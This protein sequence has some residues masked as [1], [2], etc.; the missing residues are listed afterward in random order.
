MNGDGDF[1]SLLPQTALTTARGDGKAVALEATTVFAF[2]YADGVIVA[3]D[4]RATA[5]N[6]V[7]SDRTEKILELD[8][9]SL[10]AIAGSPAIAVEMARTLQTAFDFY[11]RSQLQPMSLQAKM[12][13]LSRLLHDNLPATLQGFGTVAPLFAGLDPATMR[14]SIYFYDPLGAQFEGVKHAGSGSGSGSIKSVLHFL[15]QW[16]SPTPEKMTLGEA[17]NL[18]N[19]L[20][21]TAAE[22]DTATGGVDPLRGDFATIKVLNGAG[23][24]SITPAAQAAFWQEVKP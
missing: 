12:R 17:V 20:L 23:V 5:G 11:R 7:F 10:I 2:H 8:R 22:F 21:M 3:G 16:G 14:P 18:A 19:R 4:H 9:H 24:R 15:E 1:L 13:A 6:V